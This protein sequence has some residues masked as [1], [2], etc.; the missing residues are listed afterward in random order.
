MAAVDVRVWKSNH[1]LLLHLDVIIYPCHNL[2]CLLKSPWNLT[3]S[4]ACP[5][6]CD[7]PSLVSQA[8]LSDNDPH[9]RPS[10]RRR[11]SGGYREPVSHDVEMGRC[12]HVVVCFGK[13]IIRNCSQ[14][15]VKC[16]KTSI[17]LYITHSKHPKITNHGEVWDMFCDFKVSL[18]IHTCHFLVACNTPGLFWYP[19]WSLIVKSIV[20]SKAQ[21]LCLEFFNYSKYWQAWVVCQLSPRCDGITHIVC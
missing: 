4:T 13:R 7:T 21:D 19:I 9:S 2:S 6:K 16:P 12:E 15:L 18:I 20:I 11:N 8:C 14:N 17:C 1:T 10:V 3:N 5:G